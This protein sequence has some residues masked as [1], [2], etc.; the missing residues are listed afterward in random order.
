MTVISLVL[1]IH[2]SLNGS[3]TTDSLP[4]AWEAPN[5]VLAPFWPFTFVPG[6][7]RL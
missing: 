6:H 5:L 4:G 3:P 1:E 7:T 2:F